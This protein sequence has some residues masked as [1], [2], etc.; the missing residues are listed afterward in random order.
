MKIKINSIQ[1]GKN[2]PLCSVTILE[3]DTILFAEARKKNPKPT[4]IY[5][6]PDKDCKEIQ[7]EYPSTKA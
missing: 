5:L 2:L 1:E 7:E 4:V 6:L 3:A